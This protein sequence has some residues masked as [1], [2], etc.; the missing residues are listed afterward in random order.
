MSISSLFVEQNTRSHAEYFDHISKEI[1][2]INKLFCAPRQCFS[3]N[4]SLEPRRGRIHTQNLYIPC[5]SFLIPIEKKL[6]RKNESFVL[7]SQL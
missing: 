1:L 3:D 6:S 4:L 5:M 2:S 7:L